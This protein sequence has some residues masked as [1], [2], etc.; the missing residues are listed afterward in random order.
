[1][2][3]SKKYWLFIMGL[4]FL[5]ACKPASM[6]FKSDEHINV[7]LFDELSVFEPGIKIDSIRVFVALL[8]EQVVER[9][10]VPEYK[11]IN[12]ES[13]K[14]I[15]DYEIEGNYHQLYFFQLFSN[16]DKRL[17]VFLATGWNYK[18]TCTSL[19]PAYL[20]YIREERFR[21]AR[22]LK[23]RQEKDQY[24][25]QKLHCFPKKNCDQVTLFFYADKPI[26]SRDES[27]IRFHQ[28]IMD[29]P[30]KIAG[31]KPVIYNINRI[32]NDPDAMIFTYQN[33]L[34]P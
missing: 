25:L 7:N 20:G 2:L 9:D 27:H 14:Q 32:F 4:A 8:E 26:R 10:A 16:P 30:N 12:S 28:I 3:N 34:F 6:S 19:G 29:S 13:R 33:T 23:I 24:Q 18:D 11:L 21:I 17:A 22:R 1:M 15:V 31:T 5:S